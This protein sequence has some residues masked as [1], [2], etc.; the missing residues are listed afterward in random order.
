MEGDESLWNMLGDP[1]AGA[2]GPEAAAFAEDGS[3]LPPGL[4][5]NG[6]AGSSHRVDDLVAAAF[7]HFSTD[8][9]APFSPPQG[10]GSL[11]LEDDISTERGVNILTESG[12]PLGASEWWDSDQLNLGDDDLPNQAGST[13]ES[14]YQ[15]NFNFVDS[16]G[17]DPPPMAPAAGP[18]QVGADSLEPPPEPA[19]DD[20]LETREV[21][22]MVR[23][24]TQCG[25]DDAGTVWSEEEHKVLLDRLNRYEMDMVSLC[26]KIAFDLPKKTAL[27]V[28]L[29]CRWFQDKEK[30]AKQSE[31]VQKDSAGGKVKIKG[32]GAK[33]AK[34]S[35]KIY[36]LSKEALDSK[37]TKELI[38]DS[39]KF[40]KRIEE[41]LK[42]GQ[43][44]NT[45]DYFYYVKTIIDAVEK[46]T[47]EFGISMTMPPIDGEGLE[48]ILR[49]RLD[50]SAQ[51]EDS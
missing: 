1:L 35:K 5:G 14:L 49:S 24:A 16:Q 3:S 37:S 6:W 22:E 39:Y 48:E 15:L 34:N 18:N 44:D 17:T 23:V 7:A 2:S 50:S 36:P 11:A 13:D 21:A 12:L 9:L 8:V 33:G 43:L 4:P 45:V 32:N 26:F 38:Q 10:G 51:K 47:S 30:T 29:R 46:R 25:D 40:L 28:A 41:N 27:D 31:S 19:A 42:T 20:V